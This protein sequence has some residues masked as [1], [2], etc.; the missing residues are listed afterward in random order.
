MIEGRTVYYIKNQTGADGVTYEM[1][2]SAEYTFT[3]TA[4]TGDSSEK[5]KSVRV[6]KPITVTDG[7]SVKIRQIG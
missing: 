1:G 2:D 6:H 4:T 5:I 7:N 3:P